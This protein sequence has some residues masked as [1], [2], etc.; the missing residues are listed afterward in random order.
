MFQNLSDDCLGTGPKPLSRGCNYVVRVDY[1]EVRIHACMKGK[2]QE[3][4][5][6]GTIVT[7][8]AFATLG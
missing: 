1:C 4:I 3:K 5:A 7:Y 6:L 2:S 8:C